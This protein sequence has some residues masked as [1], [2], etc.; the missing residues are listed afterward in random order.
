M[1]GLRGLWP[2]LSRQESSKA[3]ALGNLLNTFPGRDC[4]GKA[5]ALHHPRRSR[6]EGGRAPSTLIP[7][8][9]PG[10]SRPLG[11]HIVGLALLPSPLPLPLPSQGR[12]IP[13]ISMWGSIK[14]RVKFNTLGV[15]L[16]KCYEHRNYNWFPSL[17]SFFRLYL[18]HKQYN[19]RKTI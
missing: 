18:P 11:A 2:F 9:V 7:H 17:L 14:P 4:W 3:F 10:A 6:D 16:R 8:R 5:K 15:D 1:H 12:D 13:R 19:T